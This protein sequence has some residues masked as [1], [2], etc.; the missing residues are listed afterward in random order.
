MCKLTGLTLAQ[1]RL[2]RAFGDNLLS[3]DARAWIRDKTPA[4]SADT[5]RGIPLLFTDASVRLTRYS[6]C[7]NQMVFAENQ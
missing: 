3:L 4:D 6:I 7:K 5:K 1:W 2:I